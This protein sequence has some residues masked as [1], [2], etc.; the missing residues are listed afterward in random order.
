M[1]NNN[2]KLSNREREVLQLIAKE[3]TTSEIANTL[4]ITFGTVESHRKNLR[5]KLDAKN[6]AGAIV[7]AI[8]SGDLVIES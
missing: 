4:G 7:K 3:M 8:S 6:I 2:L 5:E 1:Q